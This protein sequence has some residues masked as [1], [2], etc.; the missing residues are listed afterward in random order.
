MVREIGLEPTRLLRRQD[1]NLLR[2]PISPLSHGIV[3]NRSER[4]Q[5]SYVDRNCP[6]RGH[7]DGIRN[8][9]LLHGRDDGTRNRSHHRD[10]D[11]DTRSR[12]LHHGRDDGT[13]SR[14]LHHG[15]DDGTRNRSLPHDRDDGNRI[16][17]H[18][19]GARNNSTRHRPPGPAVPR[20]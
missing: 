1:L 18:G 2:L 19:D 8:R 9:S 11:D 7:D 13:R 3:R 5:I 12:S 16:L 20:E 10:H 15:R 14:S 4:A 17:R 6:Y